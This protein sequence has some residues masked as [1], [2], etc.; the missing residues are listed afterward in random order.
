MFS[1][2]LKVVFVL[3]QTTINEAVCSLGA[4]AAALHGYFL[5]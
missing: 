3:I 5:S 2:F 4:N 1:C